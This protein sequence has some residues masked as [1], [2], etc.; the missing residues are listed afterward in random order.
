MKLSQRICWSVL[1]GSAAVAMAQEIPAPEAPATPTP[2][3]TAR[4][5][6]TSSAA[7]GRMHLDVVVDDKA[8]KAVPGLELKDFTLMDNNQPAPILSF[9]AFDATVQQAE[10]PAEVIVPLDVV[11]NEFQTISYVREGIE[12]FLR[13]NGGKLAQ[14]VSIL[15]FT[16]DGA[17]TVLKPTMDGN[18]LAG[19]LSDMVT[20]M[21]T[22]GRSGGLAGDGER[23]ELSIRMLSLIAKTETKVPGRKLLIWAGPGWPLLNNV[24]IEISNKD[25]QMFFDR[26]VLL[27]GLL[28][29][30][31]I[32]LYSISSGEVGPGTFVYRGYL[33]GVKSSPQANPPNLALKVLATQSGGRVLGPDNDLTAQINH[34]VE[35]AKA[36]YRISFDP[37]KAD[38]ANEYHDLK[39]QV[40]Q[41]GLTARTNSGYYNQP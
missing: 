33:K 18:A 11:N 37:P 9:H 1:L 31:Q 35:D 15:L 41:P 6:A 28:R 3:V 36:Y 21:R 22:I 8:G 17:K 4:P 7:E 39:L 30:A 40:D 38:R 24:G 23:F 25:Q 27:S 29:E 14:P 26:I 13:Q 5:V 19:Q 32:S 2:V 34:I 12:K 10:A 16:N 20:G